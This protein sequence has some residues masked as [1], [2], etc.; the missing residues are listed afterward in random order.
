M[1]R[2]IVE[3]H[4]I[5]YLSLDDIAWSAWAVRKPLQESI[6]ELHE[7]TSCQTGWIVGGC[8][9]DLIEAALSRCTELGFL[10]PGVEAC[11]ANCRKRPWEPDKYASPEEQD[12]ALDELI[13]WVRAYETRDDVCSLACHRRVYDNFDG[14][15]REYR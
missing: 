14:P 15:K 11:V 12:K 1:A 6:A 9:G 8:Y 13:A 4:N 2:Q 5:A 7:F 3:A 10:N